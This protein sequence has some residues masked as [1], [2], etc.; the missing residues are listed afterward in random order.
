MYYGVR[1]IAGQANRSPLVP[2]ATPEGMQAS[3]EA[4]GYRDIAVTQIEA[5]Q[6]FK[7]FDEFWEINTL[8]FH[9]VGKSVAQLSDAQRAKLRD[10]MRSTLP[11]AADGSITYPARCVAFKARK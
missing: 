10:H 1:T 9:P 5:S 8:S 11:T 6:S 4:A 2:E 7:D 3:L